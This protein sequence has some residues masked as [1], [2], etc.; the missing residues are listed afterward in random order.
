[1][2]TGILYVNKDSYVREDLPDT[3]T[4]GADPNDLHVGYSV[5]NAFDALVDFDFTGASGWRVIAATLYLYVHTQGDG[6][7]ITAKQ[8]DSSWTEA[9]VTWNSKPTTTGS[10]MGSVSFATTGWKTWAI[11]TTLVQGW[12]SG[13]T[14]RYGLYLHAAA[15]A[16]QP[17]AASREYGSGSHI[18]YLLVETNPTGNVGI[19]SPTM[20]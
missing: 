19:G 16:A 18:G 7:G 14:S 5:A 12:V 4:H 20:I 8:I 10:T 15:G 3:G 17:A 6:T 13:G 2:A 11:S 1:M 9:T